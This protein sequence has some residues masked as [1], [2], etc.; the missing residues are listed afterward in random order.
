MDMLR[1]ILLLIGLVVVA[2]I[3]LY[4]REPN[5]K[6]EPPSEDKPSPLERLKSLFTGKS[7][8]AD[9]DED[10]I[11]PKITTED[12]EQLGSMVARRATDD[13]EDLDEEMHA[14]WDSTTPVAPGDEVVLVFHIMATKDKQFTGDELKQAAEQAGFQFG[15]MQIFHFY[16]RQLAAEGDAIC[17]MANILEPGYFDQDSLDSFISPGVT[18]F[19]QLPGPLEARQA[20]E[21]TLDKA[22]EITG[23]LAGELCDE[24]HNV[25][26][27]QTISHMKE[28]VESFRFKQQVAAIKQRRHER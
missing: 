27:E 10:W 19:M 18:L 16:G 25:L 12:F 15:D 6:T 2:G 3:Y 4:Y 1:L 8:Q 13:N 28:K 20:F 22:R 9:D 26:T 21:L 23:L 11:H 7:G 5:E 17:S 24:S 14:S